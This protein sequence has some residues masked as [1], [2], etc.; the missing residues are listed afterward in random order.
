VIYR[1][2]HGIAGELG[3]L[4][5]RDSTYRCSCNRVGCL[6]T[7][8][9]TPGILRI[10]NERL[11][12][13]VHSILRFRKHGD[14]TL[15]LDDI[16]AAAANGD[17]F[18][19]TTL[20]EIGGFIGDACATLVKILNPG[21]IVISGPVCMFKDFLQDAIIRTLKDQVF[22]EMLEDLE[23]L[24]AE[25]RTGQEACGAAAFA[26]EGYLRRRIQGKRTGSRSART[27]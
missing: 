4:W 7:I 15:R 18:A 23:I 12:E 22:Q 19:T 17:R 11:K 26:F 13:G 8:V 27:A 25:H 5:H 10:F 24:F 1:G 16:L 21:R 9:S 3:H 6:E 14:E 20:Q 2:I